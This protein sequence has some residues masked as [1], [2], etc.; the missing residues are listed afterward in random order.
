MERIQIVNSLMMQL[1]KLYE[2]KGK[3]YYYRE[4]FER[5][6]ATFVKNTLEE[7][8]E[9]IAKFLN[10]DITPARIKLLANQRRSYK[11]KKKDEV[12]LSNIKEALTKIQEMSNDFNLISNEVT[13][14][15]TILFRGYDTVRFNKKGAKTTRTIKSFEDYSSEQQLQKL[16][17]QYHTVLKSNKYELILIICN[18][19]VDFIKIEPFT[20]YNELIGLMLIYTMISKEFQVCRFG[21]FFAALYPVKDRLDNALVQANYD[22]ENGL[23]QTDALV[24]V[25]IDVL[26]QLHKEVQAKEHVYSF[27]LKLNKTNTIESIIMNG[28]AVFTKSSIRKKAPLASEST[29]NR[30]LQ[31]LKTDGIIRPLGQGRSATWQR[32][33]DPHEK[34]NAQQLTLFSDED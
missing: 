32:V 5:D 19:Y 3:A 4:L 10:L 34:F 31:L 2:D 29:I 20:K 16:I 28:P 1:F 33:K 8:T 25:I 18:F 17:D 27:D 30:T 15:V 7:D 21:S 22:W 12:L 6:D 24:R 11:P 23:S 13:D 26:E 14:L 9:N